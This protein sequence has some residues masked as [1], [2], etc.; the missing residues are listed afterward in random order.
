[1]GVGAPDN[2]SMEGGTCLSAVAGVPSH[3]RLATLATSVGYRNPA[4][5]AKIAA[6]VDLISRGRLTLGIGAGYFET[7]RLRSR[8]GGTEGSNPV[9]SSSESPSRGRFRRID[10]MVVAPTNPTGVCRG[11]ASSVV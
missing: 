9:P 6:G 2:P 7:T 5:L 1:G 10:A 11:D 4:H 8:H 3:I